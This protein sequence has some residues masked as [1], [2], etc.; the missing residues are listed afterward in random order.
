MT[1]FMTEHSYSVHDI[2]PHIRVIMGMVTGLG[3]TR[4]LSG[5][6]RIVQH[7][8]RIP[9]SPLHLAWVGSILLYLVH[10]W[11]WE[12]GLYQVEN[13]T[14]GTYLFII[15]YAVSLFLLCALLFPDQLYDYE[16]YGDYFIARR[17]WFFG[18]LAITY[19]LD[20]VDALIKGDVHFSRFAHEY[21]IRTPI[22]VALCIAAI[23]TA[24]SRFH[25]IFIVATLAYQLSWIFR[26]FRTL[27]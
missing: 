8:G 13:W 1:V 14:F 16:S 21:L 11:W 5:I 6:A 4:L 23:R 10:F 18:V 3:I 2:Y 9:L 25:A 17:A 7:P 24:S 15:A 19:M 12:F 27:D 20:V 22:L 26:L